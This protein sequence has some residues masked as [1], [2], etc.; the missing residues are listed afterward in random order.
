MH[1]G[2]VLQS[3]DCYACPIKSFKAFSDYILMIFD[4]DLNTLIN[5]TVN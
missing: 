2:Q 3:N 1:T 4:L 5:I